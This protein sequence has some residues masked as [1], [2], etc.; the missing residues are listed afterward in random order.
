L[1]AS[2]T[3]ACDALKALKVTA[4]EMVNVPGKIRALSKL[5]TTAPVVVETSI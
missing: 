3:N 4:C 1:D 5:A 2:V